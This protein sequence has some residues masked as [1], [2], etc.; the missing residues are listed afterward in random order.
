M[1]FGGT[2]M[3]SA[4]RIKVAA[5]IISKE[6][7]KRPVV[8]VVSA[9][10]KVTDLLLETLRQAEVGDRPLVE[11][12]IETLLQRHIVTCREL[13]TDDAALEDVQQLV[14]EFRRIAN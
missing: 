4:A 14:G 7:R 13:F 12:S 10:S 5:E 9:M 11:A 1:K 2:S 3:G 8:V 6:Q